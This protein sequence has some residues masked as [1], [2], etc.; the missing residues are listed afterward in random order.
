MCLVLL[1]L[2]VSGV[3]VLV[4]TSRMKQFVTKILTFQKATIFSADRKTFY[5]RDGNDGW[6]RLARAAPANIINFW[7]KTIYYWSGTKRRR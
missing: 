1:S 5:C 6:V 7:R 2:Y 3:R 4:V